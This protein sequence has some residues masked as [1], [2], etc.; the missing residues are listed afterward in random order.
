MKPRLQLI[1]DERCP[2]C[3]E[4][5]HCSKSGKCWCFE[6]STTV[7]LLEEVQRTYNSCL[8]PKCLNELN[9]KSKEK[10]LSE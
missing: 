5:F 4:A 2:R 3:G 6:V 9:E 10:D 8:C 7:S 1:E